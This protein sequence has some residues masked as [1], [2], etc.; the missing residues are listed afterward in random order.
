MGYRGVENEAYLKL[1]NEITGDLIRSTDDDLVDI[2]AC[3]YTQHT[4]VQ[5][6]D[7]V[8]EPFIS[9]HHLI[10]VQSYVRDTIWLEYAS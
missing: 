8:V 1:F 3:K 2:S 5:V 9:V 7:R 4:L 6:H 10:C